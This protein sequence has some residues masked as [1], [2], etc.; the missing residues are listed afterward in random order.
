M[1][2]KVTGLPKKHTVHCNIASSHVEVQK[3]LWVGDKYFIAE[4]AFL[5]LLIVLPATA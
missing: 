4:F 1:K 2:A 5:I 3:A